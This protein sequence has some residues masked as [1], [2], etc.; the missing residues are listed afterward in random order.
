MGRSSHQW[1]GGDCLLREGSKQAAP[2]EWL[3]AGRVDLPKDG[4]VTGLQVPGGEPAHPEKACQHCK[5]PGA[6][7]TVSPRLHVHPGLP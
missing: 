2:Q 1:W 6:R 5:Q 7:R 4:E 3:T